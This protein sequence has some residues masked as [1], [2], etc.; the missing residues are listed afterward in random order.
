[1]IHYD[2]ERAERV[3][4]MWLKIIAVVSVLFGIG[5]YFLTKK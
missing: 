1:M 3:A 4:S 5:V 2:E